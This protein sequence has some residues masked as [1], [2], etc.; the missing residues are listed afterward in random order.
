MFAQGITKDMA[1]LNNELNANLYYCSQGLKTSEVVCQD[2]IY[3]TCGF[4]LSPD[5]ENKYVA[6]KWFDT[7]EDAMR[8]Y[9]CDE[10]L[11]IDDFEIVDVCGEDD[12]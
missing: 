8:V 5:F 10:S 12:V 6:V 3:S 4:E 7:Y 9:L 2:M 1:R 11:S